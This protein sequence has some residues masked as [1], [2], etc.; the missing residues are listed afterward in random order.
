MPHIS[1]YDLFI[2]IKEFM[3]FI[4]GSY[5]NIGTGVNGMR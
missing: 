1:N 3:I 2:S 4:V 5:K